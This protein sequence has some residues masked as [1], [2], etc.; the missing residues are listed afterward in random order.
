MIR[1]EGA[2]IINID[3]LNIIQK[4]VNQVLRIFASLF[5]N[6]KY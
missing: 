2:K 3:Y 6:Q 5:M 1:L 4:G